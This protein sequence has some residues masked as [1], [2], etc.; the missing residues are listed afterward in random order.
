MGLFS[1]AP[2]IMIYAAYRGST[3]WASAILQCV[4]FAALILILNQYRRGV[5]RLR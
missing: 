2:L 3:S 4:M 5:W 1:F